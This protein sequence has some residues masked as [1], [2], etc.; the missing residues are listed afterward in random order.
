[1]A[2]RTTK[3]NLTSINF[4][5]NEEQLDDNIIIISL[6]ESVCFLFNETEDKIY[7]IL[8]DIDN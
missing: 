5:A 8:L 4:A 3:S 2:L 6:C 7:Y 1:M